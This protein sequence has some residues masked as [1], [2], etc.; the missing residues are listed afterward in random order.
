M[1]V[2]TARGWRPLQFVKTEV[3]PAPHD[4][5]LQEQ[6]GF[7]ARGI[8]RR[9]QFVDAYCRGEFFKKDKWPLATFIHAMKTGD[10]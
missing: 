2:M 1:H 9:G 3:V 6:E 5:T 4:K 8:A 10:F 7:T